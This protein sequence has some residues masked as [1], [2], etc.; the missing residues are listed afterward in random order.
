MTDLADSLGPIEK[1]IIVNATA[2]RAFDRFTRQIA[3]WW[4]LASF[5]LSG[6]TA[7][8]LVFEA[9]IGGA[10][11]EVDERGARREWGVVLH[12]EPPTRLV[13]S[14]VLEQPEL[15]TVVE[16][17]FEEIGAGRTEL[18]LIHRGWQEAVGDTARR[19]SYSRGWPAVLAAFDA[20]L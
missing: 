2:E 3:V 1:R 12:C 19:D 10:I 14:W 9:R 4:P 20:S 13:F 7:V 8:D 15:A 11:Y 18:T 5:S 6:A 17:L 16:V